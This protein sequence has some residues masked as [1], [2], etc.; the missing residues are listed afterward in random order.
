MTRKAFDSWYR[1]ITTYN[2]TMPYYVQCDCGDLAQKVNLKDY[3]ECSK[4]K[5]K[6]VLRMGQYVRL[7]P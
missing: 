5:S 1:E 7:E 2:R 3:F 6:Y 4:C